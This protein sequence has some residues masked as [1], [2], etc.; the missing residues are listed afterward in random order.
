MLFIPA[1]GL[2][3]PPLACART[4]DGQCDKG[5]GRT[6]LS[7]QR[8]SAP[9]LLR[10]KHTFCRRHARVRS[11]PA[12][13]LSSSNTSTILC[14]R[15]D[16]P[17]FLAT[18]LRNNA[19]CFILWNCM[20][21]EMLLSECNERTNTQGQSASAAEE[22]KPSSL[23]AVPPPVLSSMDAIPLHG[24]DNVCIALRHTQSGSYP[25]AA[26]NEILESMSR[27]I[28]IETGI[29]VQAVQR[30]INIQRGMIFI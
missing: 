22:V 4:K 25:D 21:A 2:S 23:S 3:A 26:Q 14:E 17:A 30:H 16:A 29:D 10:A 13:R 7:S 5:R 24:R 27:C 9:Q 12:N 11:V 20:I 1:N 8:F 28:E 15:H 6:L 18:L 19:T